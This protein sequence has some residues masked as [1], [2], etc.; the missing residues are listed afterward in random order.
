MALK[1]M[2]HDG[3]VYIAPYVN[4]VT[5]VNREAY[6]N[7]FFIAGAGGQVLAAVFG[8]KPHLHCITRML[9]LMEERT[10][11]SVHDYGACWRDWRNIHR[12]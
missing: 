1:A 4:M 9:Q 12:L 3:G 8:T 5:S 6:R 7:A 10:Y 2:E 11:S